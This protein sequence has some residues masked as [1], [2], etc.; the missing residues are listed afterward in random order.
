MSS[1]CHRLI[2]RVA[3]IAIIDDRCAQASMAHTD[4]G[5]TAVDACTIGRNLDRG[6]GK[7]PSQEMARV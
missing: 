5:W 2:A 3:I 6:R 4:H 1:R 7:P